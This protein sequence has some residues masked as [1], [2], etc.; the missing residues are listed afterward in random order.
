MDRL[1]GG[2]ALLQAQAEAKAARDRLR[3]A[4]D[5]FPEGVVFLD[6]EG[7][8]ILWND[9]YAEIY[10][11]SAD[12]FAPGRALAETLRIGVERG[13]YP[14]ALG[15]EEAWL[16][17]RLAKLA[18]PDGERLEQQLSDGRW[19]MI[20]DRRTADGGLIGL[21]VDITEMKRQAA[22]LEGA[23]GREAAASRAKSEFLAD[24]SHEL[25]TPLN[26]VMGLAQALAATDLDAAQRA[27]VG[28]LV[29]SGVRL[30]ALVGG[31]L[32]YEPH[33]TSHPQAT[34]QAVAEAAASGSGDLRVL[35]A[36]DNPTNRRVVELMLDAAG[37]EVVSVED[38]AQALDALREE[39]FD[40]VL[41]DLRMPVMDG[42]EAIRAIR[43]HEGQGAGRLPIIVLSA[44]AAPEDRAAS[45]EAGADRHIA[46]PIRAETL[47]GAISEVLEG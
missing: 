22:A 24:M 25:R 11:R 6:R 38:G 27:I 29:E 42:F 19:L 9:R 16:E 18:N 30:E 33:V 5:A 37:I 43:A 14:E 3:A 15:Q 1:I 44:N 28:D 45:A 17:D 47:F 26:G 39:A 32:K 21:R 31:L 40:L 2:R 8:Y 4:I 34:V 10:H 46:K 35:L 7:R 41:M 20:E 13:D 36:D 12:L 23:L